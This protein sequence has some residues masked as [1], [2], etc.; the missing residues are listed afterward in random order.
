[1]QARYTTTLLHL[2]PQGMA[3]SRGIGSRLYKF[4]FASAGELA[5]IDSS[6]L[7]LLKEII[8]LTTVQALED[9]ERVLGL[10]STCKALGQSLQER[11]NAVIAKLQEDGR[12]DK[13]YF[14]E[15]A[16]TLGYTVLITE[17]RPFVAGRSRSG[18]QLYN[19]AAVRLVW[20]VSV[21]GQRVQC[22][23]TGASTAGERL[24]KISKAQDLECL[25][26]L[27]KQAHTKIVWAYE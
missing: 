5:K 24:L 26:D 25:F 13:A 3:W 12:Q 16:K 14:V 23:R 17:F 10:P 21:I 1:M 2:L 9:W 6:A 7:D 18:H 27:Q 20:Q 8:P 19:G 4:L 15:L 11:R 22:F